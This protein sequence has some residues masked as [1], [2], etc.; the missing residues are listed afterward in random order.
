MDVCLELILMTTPNGNRP[1][2]DSGAMSPWPQD[3]RPGFQ[4][5]L[6]NSPIQA[7][8]RCAVSGGTDHNRQKAP[9]DADISG[10][11]AL[12]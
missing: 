12:L 1:D 6:R 5:S 4:P 8:D 11:R 2:P 9:L 10:R 3:R 7:G